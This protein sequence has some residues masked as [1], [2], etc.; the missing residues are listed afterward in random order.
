MIDR[1][2]LLSAIIISAW[3]Y[4]KVL[5]PWSLNLHTFAFYM[6]TAVSSHLQLKFGTYLLYSKKMP[7][8][9]LQKTPAK[10]PK[11]R[12]WYI[13]RLERAIWIIHRRHLLRSTTAHA[14]VLT[15]LPEAGMVQTERSTICNSGIQKTWAERSR[16]LRSISVIPATPRH[17][18]IPRPVFKD[19]S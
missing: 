19:A 5:T 15:F 10:F 11:W 6:Y 8:T 18:W 1:V 2:E 16:N 9:Q 3:Q 14:I 13:L 12:K 7:R 17:L 4:S